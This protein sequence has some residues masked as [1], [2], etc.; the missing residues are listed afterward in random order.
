MSQM[1]SL[2]KTVAQWFED[3]PPTEWNKSHFKTEFKCDVLLNNYYEIFNSNILE[4]REKPIVIILEWIREY[5]MRRLQENR[6]RADSKW[7]GVLC[8]KIAKIVEKN[9]EKSIDC[10]PIKVDFFHWQ[11]NCFDS[12]QHAADLDLQ[13]LLL[14]GSGI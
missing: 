10:I 7:K 11:L 8:P 2:D 3:K 5:L 6:A 1:S 12:S 13:S 14:A 4:A 9:V